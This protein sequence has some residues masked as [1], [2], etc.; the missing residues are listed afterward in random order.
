MFEG[1]AGF[2]MAEAGVSKRTGFPLGCARRGR[3]NWGDWSLYSVEGAAVG[4]VLG[5]AESDF[6]SGSSLGGVGGS[7][8]EG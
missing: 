3:W 7:L 1:M 5:P 8:G 6:R 2:V 4:G